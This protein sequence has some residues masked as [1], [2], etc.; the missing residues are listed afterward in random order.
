MNI[1]SKTQFY[2]KQG[3]QL[4]IFGPKMDIIGEWR[5]IHNEKLRGLYCSPKI[6]GVIKPRK[7][8]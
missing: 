3:K 4:K 7:V 5:R 6:I 2:K 1:G 8:R